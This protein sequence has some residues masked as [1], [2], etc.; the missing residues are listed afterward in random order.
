LGGA[1]ILGLAF[2]ARCVAAR[3]MSD[4]AVRGV[5]LA[6]LAYQPLLL[7]LMIFDTVSG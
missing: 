4:A 7:A 6:S 5:F 3:G 2:L 1:V